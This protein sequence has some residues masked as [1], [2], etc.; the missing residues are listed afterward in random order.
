MSCFKIINLGFGEYKFYYNDNNL[1]SISEKVQN[2][3]F[4]VVY[5]VSLGVAI[6]L[7]PIEGIIGTVAS[8]GFSYL[9][10]KKLTELIASYYS[11]PS[12]TNLFT[13][14]TIAALPR[15]GE[16][17]EKLLSGYATRNGVESHEQKLN[18]IQQALQNIFISGCY[19]GGRAFDQVLDLIQERMRLLPELNTKI[20]ASDMFITSE[21]Q[22]RIQRLNEEFGNR[23]KVVI[24]P[25][26]Y[27]YVSPTT[28]ELSFTTQH[29]KGLIIDYGRGFMVG[30]SG[31]VSTWSEQEGIAS[32]IQKESHG[33]TYDHLLTMKAFRDMDFV[34]D[35]SQLDGIG[36]RIYV[37]MMKLF[38]RFQY[39]TP[40]PIQKNWGPRLEPIILPE[41]VHGIQAACYVSGPETPCRDFLDEMVQQV[42]NAR[43]SIVIAHLYFNPPDDLLDALI[44]AR[45]R[46]VEITLITNKLASNSP[47]SHMGF[48]SLSRLK[49]KSLYQGKPNVHMFEFN[50]PYTSYHKKVMVFDEETT[51]LGS[52]NLGFKSLNSLDYEINLKV[53]SRD[54]SESI[55]RKIESDKPLC[56][57]V[58]DP[59]ISLQTWI[60]AKLQTLAAPLA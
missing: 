52:S 9:T 32:P 15:L 43:R 40:N 14:R 16:V 10:L 29:T 33:P 44:Q 3:F 39:V 24:T 27:P 4:T 1:D 35:S 49:A 48:A 12:T 25:E 21:N 45:D 2:V 20:L 8:V 17:S 30:G 34:F 56:Q 31:I 6:A 38:S 11:A 54:F 28:Q 5:G 47:G 55:L 42:Q 53:I 57:K 36:T 19:C 22:K 46:G 58:L 26:V 18:L 41:E 23:F 13:E 7:I 60:L 59:M 37:E 51:L 50:V